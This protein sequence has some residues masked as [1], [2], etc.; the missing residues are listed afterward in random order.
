M[1]TSDQWNLQSQYRFTGNHNKTP[2]CKYNNVHRNPLALSGPMGW[3]IGVSTIMSIEIRLIINSIG[4]GD[5]N[6][7][8]LLLPLYV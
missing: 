6:I 8:V 2:L 4:P 7:E 5:S 3:I 1:G